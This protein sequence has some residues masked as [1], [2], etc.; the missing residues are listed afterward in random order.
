MKDV[1]SVQAIIHIMHCCKCGRYIPSKFTANPIIALS[2]TSLHVC[3]QDRSCGPIL[4]LGS[5]SEEMT[6]YTLVSV[7]AEETEVHGVF[8]SFSG[9]PQ[10]QCDLHM[11]VGHVCS[12][13]S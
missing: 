1:T 3:L 11:S 6:D 2:S 5:H 9:G 4:F 7:L 10:L 13:T 12:L 8:F